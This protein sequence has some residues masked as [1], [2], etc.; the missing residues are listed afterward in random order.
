MWQQL[1]LMKASPIFECIP[2]ESLIHQNQN[3]Y[4]RALEKSD[5]KGESTDFIEFSS[6]MILKSLKEFLGEISSAAIVLFRLSTAKKI[7]RFN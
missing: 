1:L 2:I 3:L 5:V 6:E 7:N 4:Y